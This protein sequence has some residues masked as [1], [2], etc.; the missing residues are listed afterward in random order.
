MKQVCFVLEAVGD[1]QFLLHDDSYVIQELKFAQR[2]QAEKIYI[3][4]LFLCAE[5]G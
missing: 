5:L 2:S 4:A 3:S 1:F